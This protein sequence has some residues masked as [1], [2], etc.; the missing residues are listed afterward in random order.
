MRELHKWHLQK[1]VL[2]YAYT[3]PHLMIVHCIA[4]H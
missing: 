2:S 3:S 4:A 1:D